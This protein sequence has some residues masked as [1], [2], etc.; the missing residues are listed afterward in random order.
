M[1]PHSVVVTVRMVT[2]GTVVVQLGNYSNYRYN[3][4]IFVVEWKRHQREAGASGQT[5]KMQKQSEIG[6]AHV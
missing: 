6:R 1:R 3:K 5:S 2:G 4:R